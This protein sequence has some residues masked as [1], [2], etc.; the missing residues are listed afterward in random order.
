MFEPDTW[1]TRE[2]SGRLWRGTSRFRSFLSLVEHEI[3]DLRHHATCSDSLY[4]NH[5]LLWCAS[6]ALYDSFFVLQ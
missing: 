5:C 6:F 1:R 3:I 4:Y 2:R